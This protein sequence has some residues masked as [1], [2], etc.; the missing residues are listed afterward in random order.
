MTLEFRKFDGNDKTS[1][2]GSSV[3]ILMS[4]QRLLSNREWTPPPTPF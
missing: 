4:L 2:L 1:F 3:V